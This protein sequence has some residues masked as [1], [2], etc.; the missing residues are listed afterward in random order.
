MWREMPASG[1]SAKGR[2]W[3]LLESGGA[4][5]REGAAPRLRARAQPPRPRAAGN[6]GA[7]NPARV[8][9]SAAPARAPRVFGERERTQFHGALLHCLPL[10]LLHAIH[11]EQQCSNR[12]PPLLQQRA[13]ADRAASA[14]KAGHGEHY[15]RSHPSRAPHLQERAVRPEDTGAVH[16]QRIC[17]FVYIACGAPRASRRFG[18]VSTAY[19]LRQPA[20]RAQVSCGT[21]IRDGLIVPDPAFPSCGNT[22]ALEVDFAHSA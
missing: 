4:R 11:W 5:R 2:S 7:R 15:P 9:S 18:V 3:R 12:W 21:T 10:S 17:V 6:P 13:L 16:L 1:E 14:F 8:K 22:A 19:L 20:A